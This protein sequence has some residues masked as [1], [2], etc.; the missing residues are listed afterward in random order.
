MFKITVSSHGRTIEIIAQA[1]T[2]EEAIKDLK[3]ANQ[4]AYGLLTDHKETDTEG[5][6]IKCEK[7]NQLFAGFTGIYYM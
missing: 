1:K 6:I 3:Q 7:M 4:N 5:E 2:M